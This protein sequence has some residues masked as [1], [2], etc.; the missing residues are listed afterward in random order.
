MQSISDKKKE[1]LRV[2]LKKMQEGLPLLYIRGGKTFQWRLEFFK[3]LNRTN[4]IC[5]ANQIGKSTTAIQKNLIIATHPEGYPP[6]CIPSWDEL[7]ADSIGTPPLL[8][9]LYPGAKIT[10][11]E[12]ETK[13]QELLPCK[14]FE[15]SEKYGFKI[16][17]GQGR[18]PTML[19]FNSGAKLV[20]KYYGQKA[21]NIQSSSVHMVTTDEELD[22]P[23][24]YHELVARTFATKGYF[25]MVFTATAGN[26]MWR[27]AMEE[28]GERETFKKAFKQ[29]ISM[30][31]CM[32][33]TDGTVRFTEED[34]IEAKN[35][36][37]SESEILRR[38]Y[39]RFVL[40]EGRVYE[41]FN[42][43]VNVV[44]PYD[45]PK[46]W[47][48]Y[49]GIDI[50]SGGK[51]HPSAIAFVAVSPTY[52]KAALYKLWHGGHAKE[53]T[54]AKDVLDR[55]VIMKKGENVTCC[56]YDFACA[57][58]KN[59]ALGAGIPVLPAEKSHAIGETLLNTLFKNRMLDIFEMEH[60]YLLEN[61]LKGLKV[62]TLKAK[63]TDDGIDG[64]RYATSKIMFNFKN[65]EKKK[66]I[67]VEKKNDTRGDDYEVIVEEDIY[68]EFEEWN[69]Y[70]GTGD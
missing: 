47:H 9:Y 52:E 37:S 25:N 58:F 19:R 51:N 63:A 45:I 42:P 70:Y 15:N 65:I 34:I 32:K 21:S 48:K 64:L 68:S 66:E 59:I 1:I 61:E 55:Y 10:Y 44:K 17:R 53:I 38:I 62:G 12:F 67:K 28:K 2:R 56:Y 50:G 11:D 3:S 39:G 40:D 18:T 69:D 23:D 57:D 26:E 7:W 30:Y 46:H 24:F 13:W 54:T 8:W 6:L 35:L 27:C 41:S 5:A 31:D 36:C 33:Y 16:E 14:G 60:T 4:F 22:P 20:F 49:V 29:N 43:S